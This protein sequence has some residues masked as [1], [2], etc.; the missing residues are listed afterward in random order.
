MRCSCN[1]FSSRVKLPGILPM[2]RASRHSSLSMALA[3]Y[4]LPIA[5]LHGSLEFMSIIHSIRN[6]DEMLIALNV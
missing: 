1:D 3:S 6:T 5:I 2:T 4:G